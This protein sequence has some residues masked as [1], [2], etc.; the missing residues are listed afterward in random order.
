MQKVKSFLVALSFTVVAG[1]AWANPHGDGTHCAGGKC[2]KPGSSVWCEDAP[3]GACY[4][5]AQ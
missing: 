1:F 5:K 2:T 3:N 4:P